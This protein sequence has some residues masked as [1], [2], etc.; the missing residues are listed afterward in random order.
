MDIFTIVSSLLF[1]SWAGI[2]GLKVLVVL[3]VVLY[4]TGTIIEQCVKKQRETQKKDIKTSIP[5][6]ITLIGIA[7]LIALLYYFKYSPKA[8]SPDPISRLVP[9]L[10]IS[11]IVFSSISYLLDIYAGCEAGN[12]IDIFLYITFFPKVIS[13]PIVRWIDFQAQIDERTISTDEFFEGMNQ[14]AI[15]FAKK[16]LLADYFGKVILDI[17]QKSASNMD[18]PTAW[19][20]CQIK[21]ATL[22]PLNLV[23]L[24]MVR[25]EQWIAG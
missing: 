24:L 2:A 7:L 16:V 9:P 18:F 22:E 17:T 25:S 15:G 19:R 14:I 10:G 6:I 4:I 20:Y 3:I 21:F 13:G 8:L 5:K 23:M 1:Y 12:L 11:F